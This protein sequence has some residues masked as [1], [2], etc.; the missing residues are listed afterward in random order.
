MFSGL[1]IATLFQVYGHIINS[2]MHW[3]YEPQIIINVH[4]EI[5]RRHDPLGP[6]SHAT[7]GDRL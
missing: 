1:V 3:L 7:V 6:Q 2:D 4:V 5:L